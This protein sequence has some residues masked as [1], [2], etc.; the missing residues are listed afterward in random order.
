MKKKKYKQEHMEIEGVQISF[1]P[2]SAGGL[3]Y[4][5]IWFGR[6]GTCIGTSDNIRELK[7]LRKWCDQ[8]IEGKR[9]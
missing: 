8:V 1:T 7:R 2:N 3:R 4:S 6:N 5:Y 9:K